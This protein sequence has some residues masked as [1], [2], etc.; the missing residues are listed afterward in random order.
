MS[1]NQNFGAFKFMGPSSQSPSKPSQSHSKPSQSPPKLSH[2][3]RKS[4]T[5][6]FSN[7]DISEKQ[8]KALPQDL[9]KSLRGNWPNW[10][11]ISR[12]SSTNSQAMQLNYTI[13]MKR[14]Y[15][16]LSEHI[17][18]PQDLFNET[19]AIINEI[20]QTKRHEEILA[21]DLKEELMNIVFSSNFIE[22]AGLNLQETMKICQ[23]IFEGENV[24]AENISEQTEEYQAAVQSLIDSKRQRPGDANLHHVIHSR[25][26]II[27]H[28]KALD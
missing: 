17:S 24:K 5:T 26:E 22:R 18:D 6:L 1:Q 28:A 7:L 15:R 4:I 27:Q 19:C 10:G 20:R 14:N 12:S 9:A 21:S 8:R 11:S 23:K 16:E 3:P 2:R 13:R 25:R